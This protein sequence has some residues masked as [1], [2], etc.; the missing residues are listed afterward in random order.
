MPTQTLEAVYE[1]GAFRPTSPLDLALSEGE[2]VQIQVEPTT[3]TGSAEEAKA[4]LRRLQLWFAELPESEREELVEHWSRRTPRRQISPFEPQAV[5]GP[6]RARPRAG[7]E[8]DD[9]FD[10]IEALGALFDDVPEEER[11]EI[12]S[13]FARRPFFRER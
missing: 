4:A 10:V 1:G 2:S 6:A 7:G 11:L 9:G 12:E 8:T 5:N 3:H 13:H